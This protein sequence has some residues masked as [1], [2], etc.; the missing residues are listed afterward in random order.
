MDFN[1]TL[2]WNVVSLLI[3][4]VEAHQKLFLLIKTKKRVVAIFQIMYS[5]ASSLKILNVHN[6]TVVGLPLNSGN[7]H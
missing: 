2:S 5:K 4:V 3:T 1:T 7:V 6:F